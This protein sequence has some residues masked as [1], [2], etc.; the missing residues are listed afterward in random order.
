MAHQ[1]EAQFASYPFLKLLDVLV[2]ELDHPA[3]VHIDEVVVVPGRRL[4]V[5]AAPGAGVVALEEAIGFEQ[6]NGPIDRRQRDPG[7]D[8]VGATV[9]FLDIWM[10]SRSR[11]DP[12]DDPALTRHSQ[13]L[14]GA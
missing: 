8:A 7:I 14:L 12:R 13:P 11:E 1:R 5:A 2:A 6:L 9:D 10:I 3:A 4:L